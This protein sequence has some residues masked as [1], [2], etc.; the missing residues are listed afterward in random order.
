MF[1]PDSMQNIAHAMTCGDNKYTYVHRHNEIVCA[2][3]AV[4]SR[5]GFPTTREPTFFSGSVD[6][7][8]PDLVI[9]TA[10]VSPVID[11]TVVTEFAPSHVPEANVADHA[12]AAK[13]AKHAYID[14]S[15]SGVYSFFP[16]VLEASGAVHH[17]LD[18]LIVAM[19]GE[20]DLKRQ[21]C[22]AVAVALQRGNA[23]ILGHFFARVTAQAFGSRRWV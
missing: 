5:W 4:A 8:R 15:D 20:A 16:I 2:I 18:A 9:H 14:R 11:V 21:M 12:A 3:Q 1:V 19:G 23:R 7:K 22:F 13:A 6:G 10:R 17:K